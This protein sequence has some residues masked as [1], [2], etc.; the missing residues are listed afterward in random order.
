MNEKQIEKV[1]LYMFKHKITQKALA[2]KLGKSSV[3]IN[4]VLQNTQNVRKGKVPELIWN[5]Y[6]NEIVKELKEL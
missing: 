2:E 1:R 6:V 3:A 5:W 4:V